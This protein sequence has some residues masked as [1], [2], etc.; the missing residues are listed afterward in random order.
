VSDVATLHK[1]VHEDEDEDEDDEEEE[2]GDVT[3][4]IIARGGTGNFDRTSCSFR[5]LFF[6]PF[7]S[8]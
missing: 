8:F 1:S 3:K 6:F 7:A 5:F 4:G 2:D